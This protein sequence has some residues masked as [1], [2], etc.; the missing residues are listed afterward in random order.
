MNF[1]LKYSDEKNNR[2]DMW[3]QLFKIFIL[4]MIWENLW[5]TKCSWIETKTKEEKGKQC[6]IDENF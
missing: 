3:D 1:S 4:A 6:R 5:W 2:S